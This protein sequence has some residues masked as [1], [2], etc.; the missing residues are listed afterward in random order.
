MLAVKNRNLAMRFQVVLF[1][2]CWFGCFEL[3]AASVI[4]GIVVGAL[5]V[6]ATGIFAVISWPKSEVKS[7][8]AS[9]SS[10]ESGPVVRIPE[11][12]GE[13]NGVHELNVPMAELR[14]YQGPH[15]RYKLLATAETP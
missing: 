11:V 13:G 7:E 14:A 8:I 4:V 12:P 10:G 15:G 9:L 5:A 3:L 1:V 6:F 2:L